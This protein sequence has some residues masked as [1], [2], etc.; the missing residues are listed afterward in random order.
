M[1]KLNAFYDEEFQA[2]LQRDI[3]KE[4]ENLKWLQDNLGR[5]LNEANEKLMS[6]F[7]ES[8]NKVKFKFEGLVNP[9]ED[10][11]DIFVAHSDTSREIRH[12]GTL[13]YFLKNKEIL[14][15]FLHKFNKYDFDNYI[16][17]GL[18][19][20]TSE[21]CLHNKKYN[22][23]CRFDIIIFFGSD[24]N[25]NTYNS[26]VIIEAKVYSKENVYKINQ[27]E[28]T[29]KELYQQTIAENPNLFGKNT[30]LYLTLENED[31]VTNNFENI[32]WL[33]ILAALQKYILRIN[34]GNKKSAYLSFLQ[35]WIG[36][37]LGAVYKCPMEK[38]FTGKKS[39]KNKDKLI[40]FINQLID[41]GED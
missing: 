1:E 2:D 24:K 31:D 34:Q 7:K 37:F 30:C 4:D 18:F 29:Q 8:Y 16:E 28:V 36:S 35:L 13:A 5:L 41:S 33:D 38:D 26:S 25:V 12:T 3:D 23:E 22:K 11:T 19:K 14:K 15:A 40:D 9:I 17:K 21:Y 39:L 27:M 32:I 10:T 20:V 6:E